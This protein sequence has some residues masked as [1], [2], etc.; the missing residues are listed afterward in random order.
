[1]KALRQ[2]TRPETKDELISFLCFARSSADF[3]PF[4]AKNTPILRSLTQ[5]YVK[6]KWSA[7]AEREFVALREAFTQDALLRHFNVN[8]QTFLVIDAHVNGLCALL[9]QGSLEDLKIV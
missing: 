8:Q 4:I 5:K 2:A 9:C 7:E 1:V 6:F 3:I